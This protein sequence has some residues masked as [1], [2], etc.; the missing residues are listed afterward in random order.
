M[1]LI[2]IAFFF[3]DMT[4]SIFR[5]LYASLRGPDKYTMGWASLYVG[6]LSPFKKWWF[7][8][9]STISPA[10]IVIVRSFDD[11]WIYV[12]TLFGSEEDLKSYE[13]DMTYILGLPTPPA[14]ALPAPDAATHA[15]EASGL[16]TS[17]SSI[18]EPKTS[19]DITTS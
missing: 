7:G 5:T 1:I 16:N 11:D 4:R 6:G 12:H 3:L 18:A 13:K 8:H 10:T 17:S 14:D 9:I 2:R 19:Q 15:T